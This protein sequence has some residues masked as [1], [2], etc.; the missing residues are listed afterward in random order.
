[1]V[2]NKLHPLA[3]CL[4][5]P[6]C[7]LTNAVSDSVAECVEKLTRIPIIALLIVSRLTEW[8]LVRFAALRILSDKWVLLNTLRN[9]C[10][11]L[12]NWAP[13]GAEILHPTRIYT[14]LLRWSVWVRRHNMGKCLLIN[15][16]S[17]RPSLCPD[18]LPISRKL[19]VANPVT[20]Q[21]NFDHYE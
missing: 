3:L 11:K 20:H 1:M 13:S 21:L 10:I 4:R 18:Y 15:R 19:L 17:V 9:G 5:S 14:F 12:F 8:S 16:S 7:L 2:D 6:R